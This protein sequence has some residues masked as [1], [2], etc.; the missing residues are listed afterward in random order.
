MAGPIRHAGPPSVHRDG[1]YWLRQLGRGF[2]RRCP[3]CGGRKL[4]DRY[5]H[6]KDRCPRCGMLFERE[7]GFFVGAYLINF[8]CAI[9][10]LFVISI[11]FV[12]VMAFDLGIAMGWFLGTGVVAGLVVPIA[13]Y[14][15]ARTIWSALDVGMTPLTDEEIVD[16]AAHAAGSDAD[17]RERGPG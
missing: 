11:S 6:M 10:L 3:N 15:L 9:I 5:F 13:F 2:T 8:A 16:A 12:V 14:P 4:Y 1:R 17:Q 7:P